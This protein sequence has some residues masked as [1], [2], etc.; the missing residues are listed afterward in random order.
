MSSSAI[1]VVQAAYEA[2]A[3]RDAAKV[4][5]LFSRDV[6]IVQS[7][8]LPWGGHYRGHDG[9]RQFF[10]TLTT[11]LNST[12]EIERMIRAGDVVV[13]VGW[14]KGT[15][16]A[17]GATYRVPIAHVWTIRDGQVAHVQFCIDNP[18]MLT[19]LAEGHTRP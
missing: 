7:R 4:F 16:N 3:N 14:T 1:A 9:A 15:V 6:E 12:I 19:A 10:I 5:A 18:T 2:F 17:T 13:A 11:H 8:E